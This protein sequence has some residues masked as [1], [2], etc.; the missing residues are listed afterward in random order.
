LSCCRREYLDEAKQRRSGKALASRE[1]YQRQ[2][3]LL[4]EPP[5]REEVEMLVKLHQILN[6]PCLL[7]GRRAQDET[8]FRGYKA[9]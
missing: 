9:S 5:S 8:C 2:Q 6:E 4:L 1:E 3:E 7:A